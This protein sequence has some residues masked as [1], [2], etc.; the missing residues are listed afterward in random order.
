MKKIYIAIAA[1]LTINMA[2]AADSGQAVGGSV[3]AGTR[4]TTSGGHPVEVLRKAN[5]LRGSAQV[6]G[7][8]SG[9]GAQT[10]SGT[11]IVPLSIGATVLSVGGAVSAGASQG[12]AGA[13][14]AV[15]AMPIG[16]PLEV[17]NETI[18]I[19]PPNEALQ[20]KPDT[21]LEGKPDKVT[22]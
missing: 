6:A 2:H 20:R 7:K 8:L 11:T 13:S 21:Q 18:T 3:Q 5:S 1:L 22:P 15:P 9:G 4:A 17:S 16:A 19:M 10:L 14:A 12:T